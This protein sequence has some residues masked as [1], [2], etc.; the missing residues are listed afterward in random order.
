MDEGA[1]VGFGVGLGVVGGEVG[2]RVG[3]GVGL[4][5]GLGVGGGVGLG[6]GGVRGDT[7]VPSTGVQASVGR[8]F[9]HHKLFEF[10]FLYVSAISTGNK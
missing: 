9:P 3:G 8:F 6:V 4:G 7:E 10:Y 2:L 5:V 1:E